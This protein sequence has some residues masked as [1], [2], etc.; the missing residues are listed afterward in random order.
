MQAIFISDYAEFSDACHVRLQHAPKTICK[1]QTNQNQNDT[2]GRHSEQ[3]HVIQLF[4]LQG[5]PQHNGE[6]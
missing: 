3:C 2:A 4:S 6:S 5:L 1:V